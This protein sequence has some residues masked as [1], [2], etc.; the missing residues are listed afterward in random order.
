MIDDYAKSNKVLMQTIDMLAGK[1]IAFRYGGGQRIL[2]VDGITADITIDA[3]F[4]HVGMELLRK[5]KVPKVHRTEKLKEL[6]AINRMIQAGHWELTEDGTV[7]FRSYLK[8]EDPGTDI[9]TSRIEDMFFGMLRENR[10]YGKR[11][12]DR[13]TQ[14]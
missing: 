6:N 2:F 9:E 12:E 1:G 13:W 5:A 11:G 7:R 4:D 14:Y 10:I 8:I 3:D